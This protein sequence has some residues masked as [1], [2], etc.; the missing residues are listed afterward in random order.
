MNTESTSGMGGQNTIVPSPTAATFVRHEL[1]HLRRHWCWFLSLGIL[2]VV[3]GTLAIAF[4]VITSVAAVSVLA[5]VLMVAGVATMIGAFWAGKWSGFLVQLLVGMLYLAAG[6]V[7][8]ERPLMSV[9]TVTIFVA[10]SFMV[11]GLFRVLAAMTIRYPQWGWSLLNGT[12][13]FLVGLVIYRH[14]PLDALWV[15]GLLIGIEMLF[16]GWTWIMLSLTIRRIPAGA[17]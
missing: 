11:M 1:H 4:P 17:E 6:F 9:L 8:T 3:C 12:I 16:S 5:A 15:I 2:L 14:L 7:I 13:T 10:V